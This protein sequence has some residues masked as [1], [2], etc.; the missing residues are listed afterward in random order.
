MMLLQTKDKIIF[1]QE[2]I[3]NKIRIFFR[4]YLEGQL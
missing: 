1:I 4:K 3:A 2:L